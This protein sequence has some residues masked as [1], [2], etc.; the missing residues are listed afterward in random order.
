MKRNPLWDTALRSGLDIGERSRAGNLVAPSG[1]GSVSER[2]WSMLTTMR[3]ELWNHEM[4]RW[5]KPGMSQEQVLDIG[6]NLAEWANHATGSA[7]NPLP[8]AGNLLFGPKLTASK[9][10]RLVAD[11]VKTIQTIA[12]WS[13]ASAGEKA[14]AWTRLSGLA[15]YVGT[16]AL[17]LGVNWGLNKALGVDDKKNVNLF[18][19]SAMLSLRKSATRRRSWT[20]RRLRS[21]QSSCVRNR[22][23]KA[24]VCWQTPNY[25]SSVAIVLCAT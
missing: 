2:A 9:M 7:R 21:L 6:R 22:R 19:P 8:F 18:D 5:L 14:V 1:K 23:F 13:N 24:S 3:F 17:F 10:A 20:R 16:G 12:N 25:L 11:P 15:Q 4:Q